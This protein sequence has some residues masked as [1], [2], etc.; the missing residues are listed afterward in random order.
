MKTKIPITLTYKN[1]FDNWKVE[2]TS[3]G[4]LKVELPNSFDGVGQVEFRSIKKDARIK[5]LGMVIDSALTEL[6]DKE[7]I[8]PLTY[9]N[10]W[11]FVGYG[12]DKGVSKKT[13]KVKKT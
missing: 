6:S 12:K 4:G 11:P 9:E 8:T 13:K 7:G 2:F 5:W 3:K 10:D 1:W